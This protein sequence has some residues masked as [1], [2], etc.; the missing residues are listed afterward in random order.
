[1]DDVYDDVWAGGW[2][3]LFPNDAPGRF[4]GRNLPDHG[5]WWTMRWDV[6]ESSSGPI[7]SVCLSAKST[8][9]K[10]SCKKEFRLASDAA[11]LSVCYRIRSDELLPFH[12]LFKQ[13][14]AVHL[15]PECRLALP[16][17]KVHAV[18]PSFSKILHGAGPYD[19]PFVDKVDNGID[20]RVIPHRS[21][22]AREFL[23]VRD[24]PQPWCGVEDRKHGAS[25]RMEF[26]SHELPFVWL[27]LSYGGWRNL[28]TAVLEPCSNMPKDLSQAVR[29]GQSPKLEPGQEFKTKVSVTLSDLLEIT[30]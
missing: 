13:H 10:A 6:A 16:G 21:S 7:G 25:I 4:E 22:K 23:Y 9:V 8:V 14:L 2:E 17:G 20:L 19:W 29:L 26:D 1:L 5:E 27:F 12:F 3:E 11:T 30:H 24:L 18:D 15:S 28:Y